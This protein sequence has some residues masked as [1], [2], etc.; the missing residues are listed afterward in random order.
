M[1][2]K[3]IKSINGLKAQ[4][5]KDPN[6]GIVDTRTNGE[7]FKDLMLDDG[8]LIISILI[9]CIII[10]ESILSILGHKSFGISIWLL[11]FFP[12][13]SSISKTIKS[14]PF[15]K[16]KSSNEIDPNQIHPGTGYPEKA[17][18]IS[19]YGNDQM[20]SDQIW[21]ADSDVRTHC[22]IFGTTGAG[23][24]EALLSICMNSLIHSSGFI[25][26]D[27]KGDNSLFLKVFSMTRRMCR[28]DDLLLINY[29]KGTVDTTKKTVDRL[30]NTMNPFAA[31]T[32]GSLAELLISLLPGGGS[33]DMWKGRAS[34]FITALMKVLVALRDDRKLTLDIEAIR[35]YF[36]LEKL[37]DLIARTD[38]LDAHKSGLTDYVLN[39]PG[40][41]LP[42]PTK[43][44]E[45]VQQE[46]D[47]YAQHG[48]ITMQYTESFGMLADT[49]GHIMKTQLAE[50]DFF[51][52]VVNR[53]ILV[54]LLPALENSQQ[55]L[56]NL[57][58]VIV[59]SVKSM[60]AMALGSKVEGR[61]RDVV[62]AKPTNA[63]SPYVTVFDEY[64]YYAVEGAAV[65]PAQ[66][67]GLG[68][69]MIFAGQDYQA[70]KRGS[71]VE[72]ASIV[73][74][75]AI[76]ICMKLEDPTETCDIFTKAAG[77]ATVNV[78]GGLQLNKDSTMTS[79]VDSGNA[80]VITKARISP[81]DL[82]GQGSGEMHILF[83]DNFS[84]ANV[85]YA[86][87]KQ[88]DNQRVNK[89]LK[90]PLPAFDQIQRL[91]LGY[92]R[93]AR[94]FKKFTSAEAQEHQDL[95]NSFT[96]DIS[97]DFNSVI[98][99]FKY[100]EGVDVQSRAFFAL[101]AHMKKVKIEDN[102]LVDDI[103]EINKLHEVENEFVFNNTDD[104]EGQD[105]SSF[106]NDDFD[107]SL[108]NEGFNKKDETDEFVSA[109]EAVKSSV[110]QETAN[111]NVDINK[112][113]GDSSNIDLLRK[114]MQEKHKDFENFVNN[115]YNPYKEMNMDLQGL[116]TDMKSLEQKLTHNF[117]KKGFI[118]DD[119]LDASYP[120]LATENIITS[121]GLGTTYPGEIPIKKREQNTK[122]IS[123]I[124]NDIIL[125]DLD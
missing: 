19:F 112:S 74:N 52:V 98:N 105:D 28:E 96:N 54:V 109:K 61:R 63:I 119:R 70:F 41:V 57:G 16:P 89:F 51:D 47:V 32:A 116:Q 94:T 86:N 101:H 75:C 62:D 59:S 7:K 69:S 68:F 53:R 65:M 9:I 20:S 33:G 18:G 30:S 124:I 25:Y 14:L 120:D 2:K 56:G 10:L 50:V 99:A 76:K 48:Y 11:L 83:G 34:I 40:Y 3:Q 15:K 60:M 71:D 21:F 27:G 24:T 81:R 92:N 90:V 82:K 108:F 31:G 125:S 49:Y 72:A 87:P 88:V 110:K 36:A 22:L 106:I 5:E 115:K 84:R 107:E 44:N 64:G 66:A 93:I 35:S 102:K 55:S 39:L 91:T 12:V 67:R 100:A 13:L 23:K 79:Y 46:F 43:P 38:V 111:R 8:G 118:D 114:K 97:A 122:I 26:I 78:S 42:D 37:E 80:N 121:I 95:L 117:K 123:G 58:K 103:N 73:A 104:D 85:F 77:E 45:R 4:N 29:M 6:K 17:Q 113:L 1:S